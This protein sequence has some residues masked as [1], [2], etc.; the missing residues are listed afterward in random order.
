MFLVADGNNLAW[1]GF[2]SLRQAMGAETPEQLTRAALLGLTQSVVGLAVRRGEPPGGAM[3]LFQTAQPLTRLAVCFDEGRPLRRR[4]IFPGYQLGRESTAAFR[5]NERFVLE[6]IAAF[7]DAARCLPIEVVR[8]KDTEADDLIAAL[9]LGSGTTTARIASTDRDFL[10]LVDERVSIYSPVKRLVIDAMNFTEATAPSGADGRPVAFPRER[11]LD[12]RALAGDTSDDLPGIPGLGA[13]TAAR[14][15]AEAPAETYFEHPGRLEAVLGRRN[16]KLEEL[17]ASGEGH[18]IYERNRGL[19]DLRLG[20]AHFPDLTGFTRRG[21]WDEP[22]F[23]DWVAAQRVQGLDLE[24]A[25][26]T[27]AAVAHAGH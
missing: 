16:R 4:S 12:Y 11:Y 8:G 14:M 26:H 17:L 25:R 18:A 15:L 3:P 7:V 9:V 13:L 19:M 27:F 1:A 24:T 22:A 23:R 5:D 10:Q 20:A 2:H 6:A 21:A